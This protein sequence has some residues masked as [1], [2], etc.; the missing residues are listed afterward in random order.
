M[1]IN[2]DIKV[3]VAEDN[4]NL[5]KVLVNII[6]KIGFTEV[7]EVDDGEAAWE[8]VKEGGIGLVLT[9]W[10]MPGMTGLDLLMNIRSAEEPTRSLPVVMI[11]ASDTKNAIMTAGKHGVDGYIIKPFSVTTVMEK[12]NEVLHKKA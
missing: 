12:L 2:K 1:Q 11:T 10:A 5:R 8:K 4:L 3:L 6:T 7:V 9:D